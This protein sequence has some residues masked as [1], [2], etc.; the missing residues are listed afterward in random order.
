MSSEKTKILFITNRNLFPQNS[1]DKIVS[2]SIIKKLSLNHNVILYNIINERPYTQDEI[3]DLKSYSKVFYPEKRKFRSDLQGFVKGLLQ[4]KHLTMAKRESKQDQDKLRQ[5][6]ETHKPDVV[7]WDHLRT[8]SIF[9]ENP[10]VNVLLEHNNEYQISVNHARRV[11]KNPLLFLYLDYQRHLLKKHIIAMYKKL[12]HV[13]Y[14]SEYDL[15]D[16]LVKPKAYSLLNYLPL[17]FDF[18][19]H[20]PKEK[21]DIRLLFIGSLDYFPNTYGVSWFVENVFNKLGNDHIKLCIV[22]RDAPAAFVKK[23]ANWKNVELHTDVPEVEKYYLESDI[24]I[25]TIFDGAGKNIK[26]LE[27]LAYGIPIISSTFGSR[28]YTGFPIPVFNSAEECIEL[29]N[30]LAASVETRKEFIQKQKEYYGN[31]AKE[32]ILELDTL[33]ANIPGES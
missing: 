12:D 21:E 28:G 23:A 11:R 27:A 25:N 4:S 30:K 7:I 14:I 24:F 19:Q 6:I 32:S 5:I 13:I 15:K 22:G 31:Y 26:I 16:M 1:G 20:Q 9:V 33:I 29:V 2:Y 17:I 3:D 18:T 10:A 8:T